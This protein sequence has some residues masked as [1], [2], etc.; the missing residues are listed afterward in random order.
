[1]VKVVDPFLFVSAGWIPSMINS[2]RRK[3]KPPR[4][5]TPPKMMRRSKITL[6][7]CFMENVIM[8]TR[9]FFIIIEE[10]RIQVILKSL[11]GI[12]ERCVH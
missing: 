4:D 6:N 2:K 11:I 7:I 1:L 10:I 5:R 8:P 12:C 3:A 9:L